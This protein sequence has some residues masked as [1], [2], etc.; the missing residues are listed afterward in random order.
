[1][2]VGILEERVS[3]QLYHALPTVAGY[4]TAA[5]VLGT[6]V[7]VALAGPAQAADLRVGA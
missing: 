2:S 1:V 6:V 7:A 5:L 3:Q 4:T